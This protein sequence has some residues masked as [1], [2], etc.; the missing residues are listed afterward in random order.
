MY[1]F[2]QWHFDMPNMK[3][4]TEKWALKTYVQMLK[5]NTIFSKNE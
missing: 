2:W 4:W 3:W 1:S 5:E